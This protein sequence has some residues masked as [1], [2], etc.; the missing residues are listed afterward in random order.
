MHYSA[1]VNAEKFYKKYCEENIENKKI[2]DVGSYD[3]NGSMKPIFA[4]GHYI[5]TDMD[6]G[7]NVDVVSNAHNLPFETESFD[8]IISSSCFEHDDMFWMTFLE[9]SRIVKKGGYIYVQAPQNGP[10]HGHPGDN[11]RFYADSWKALAIWAKTNNYDIELVESYIDEE[12]Q[13]GFGEPFRIWNDSI[14][15]FR[16]KSINNK[17][18][19]LISSFCD[20]EEKL[21]LL[22]T[23][24]KKIK[25]LK[26]D[27]ICISPFPIKSEIV[28]LCDYFL[29]S[30]DNLV[31]DWPIK[32]IC[33]WREYT[34]EGTPIR[35]NRTVPDY[36]YAGLMQIKQLATIALQY[37]YTHFYPI[38]YDIDIN[39]MVIYE[40]TKEITDSNK[41]TIFKS[42][43][44]KDIWDV[45]LHFMVIDRVNLQKFISK[46]NLDSY[47]SKIENNAFDWLLQNQKELNYQIDGRFVEDLIFYYENVDLYNFSPAKSFKLFIEK[48]ENKKD[49]IKLFFYDVINENI[50]IM[51]NNQVI[52]TS[53]KNKL[54]IKLGF[55]SHN[56]Q[57]VSINE[58]D[59]IYDI[60]E[61]MKKLKHSFI[62]Y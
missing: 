60:T 28:N 17:K 46:I 22:E 4:K 51:V 14:G 44:G 6:A 7:P 54:L 12:T 18:V 52:C 11:W 49:E 3:M 27:V 50:K 15:I 19:V 34:I 43:R 45:G 42:K 25:E 57:N 1:Y 47:L 24:I 55:Y 10:Y 61:S 8:I 21:N 38:I 41:F 2:L 29:V 62:N 30:K 36:G 59:V 23:N 53:I 20:T 56:I 48:D 16:K 9:M 37:D 5:G 39:E 35:L 32:A 31:L 26:I 33:N 40:L 58:N 13:P